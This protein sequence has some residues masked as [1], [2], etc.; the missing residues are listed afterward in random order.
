LATTVNECVEV[1]LAEVFARSFFAAPDVDE[2][3]LAVLHEGGDLIGSDLEIRCRLIERQQSGFDIVVGDVEPVRS[4]RLGL[5]H[6]LHCPQHPP[7]R[8]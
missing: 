6:L 5:P 4:L 7:H 2:L 1:L 3:K 8:R